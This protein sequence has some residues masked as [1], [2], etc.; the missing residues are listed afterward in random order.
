MMTT[1]PLFARP[2]QSVRLL[3]GGGPTLDEHDKQFGT[4]PETPVAELVSLIEAAGLRGRGGARFPAG[5]KLA[6]VPSGAKPVVV[7]NGAEGEPLSHKDATLLTRAPHLVLDGLDLVSAAIEADQTYLYVRD[8]GAAAVTRA[9]QERR[10]STRGCHPTLIEA[11]DSFVAG[12]ESALIRRIEG[13]PALPR[14]RTVATAV[15]GVRG[16]PTVVNNVETL[17]HIA[18]IARYGA[19][20]FRSIGDRDD[21]GTMLITL[22]GAVGEPEVVEAPTG[23][24]VA[25]VLDAFGADVATLRAVLVGGY[26][27]MWVPATAFATTRVSGAGIVHGLGPHNCGLQRT[28]TIVDYLAAESAGQC[29][30]CRIGLPRMAQLLDEVVRT[31]VDNARMWEIGRLVD[32]VDGRG[33]CRHPDGTARLVRSALTTFADDITLHRRGGCVTNELCE[34]TESQS[35]E[36]TM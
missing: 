33:A 20:W 5:R 8:E 9:L 16:R 6:S 26:H 1:Q 23:V 24:T 15:S 35:E 17:A 25:E 30:P 32:L 13:G 29:G 10:G 14:D 28:A 3:A 22:S 2:P 19:P 7:A 21:P 4:L 18:L 12:E 31:R 11:P 27:G 34:P 36:M